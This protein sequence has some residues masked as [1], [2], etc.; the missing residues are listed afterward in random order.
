VTLLDL[1]EPLFQYICLLNRMARKSKTE[2]VNYSTVRSEIT[3]LLEAIKQKAQ[4]DSILAAQAT[5]LEMPIF[6]FIDSI[7]SESTLGC[8]K[9]WHMK[10][11][12]FERKEWAGDEKFFEFLDKTLSDPGRP[13]TERLT[14]FYVC[15]GLGFVGFYA[16][17]PELLRSK[18]ETVAKRIAKLEDLAPVARICPEAYEALDTRNLIEPPTSKIGAILIACAMLAIVA[19]VFNLYLFKTGTEGLL[20][21][22]Q[23]ILRQDLI[24]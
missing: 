13:A 9:E 15:M 16:G 23:A 4:G 20:A 11:F 6:F 3:R 14:I 2:S 7:I 10:R 5:E 24:K 18:M 8:A 21:S 19:I 12:A 17:Q 22:L 1:Y